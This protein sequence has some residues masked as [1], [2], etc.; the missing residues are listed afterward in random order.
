ME[1][2]NAGVDYGLGQTN[3]DKANGMRYGVISLNALSAF[4]T[5]NFEADY[6]EPHCP[7][8]GNK[9]ET[10]PSHTESDTTGEG[11]WV[12]HIVDMPEEMAGWETEEHEC[13]EYACRLCEYVFGG[14]SAFSGSPVG[15]TLDKDG[16]QGSA[17]EYNDV[18]LTKSPYYTHAAFCSPCAP[19]AGHLEYPCAEGP[20]TYCF[21]HDWFE[22]GKA[23]YPVYDVD[24][25]EL[26][27][28]SK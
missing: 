7:K 23:P 24:T 20:R 26:V 18:L 4:S 9:A 22:G 21:G 1:T 12:S 25:N 8:C 19:G 6:G 3:I 14:E 27:K 17:D 15:Y 2:N 11:K 5:E 10:I 13:V 28:Q 16:Y